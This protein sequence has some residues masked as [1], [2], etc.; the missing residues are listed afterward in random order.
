M[1]EVTGFY[2]FK[3]GHNTE[4]LGFTISASQGISIGLYFFETG[5]WLKAS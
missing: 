4:W 3:A 5:Y 1:E 2:F